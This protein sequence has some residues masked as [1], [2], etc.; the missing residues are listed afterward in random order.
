MPEIAL[1]D[2]AE[3]AR[4]VIDD[5]THARWAD[6]SARFDAT[7]HDGLSDRELAA[8]WAY[9]SE[10]AGAYQ[11]H[12]DTEAIRTGDFT[13]TNTPTF[14]MPRRVRPESD[15]FAISSLWRLDG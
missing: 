9:I 11:G 15:D 3:L 5:Y 4:V 12:G 10:L 13:T 14:L 2:A 7:M 6:V 8:G 1:S